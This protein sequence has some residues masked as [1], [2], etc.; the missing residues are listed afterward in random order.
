V[1]IAFPALVLVCLLMPGFAFHNSFRRTE[2]TNLDYK[3]FTARTTSILLAAML[4]HTL[5]LL[6]YRYLY[7]GSWPNLEHLFVLLTG[8]RGAVVEQSIS[9]VAPH[10]VTILFYLCVL[11]LMGFGLGRLLRGLITRYE[12]DV[13]GQL[14]EWIRFDTPWYYLFN[15]KIDTQNLNPD[16]VLISAIVEMAGNAYL[17]TGVLEKYFLNVDGQLDRLVLSTVSRRPFTYDRSDGSLSSENNNATSIDEIEEP[18]ERRFYPI[19][20]HYF[21]LRYAEIKTLN[22]QYF[23]F[24]VEGNNRGPTRMALT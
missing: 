7:A 4:L 11:S 18:Y 10:S 22:V 19:E 12:W 16:G 3:P 21:V 15:G 13:K 20:G 6:A 23:W 17:Y 2:K 8:Y 1:N 5:G 9:T 24:E 14:I